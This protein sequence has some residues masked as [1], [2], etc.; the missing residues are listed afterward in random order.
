MPDPGCARHDG[1]VH[2]REGERS[3]RLRQGPFQVAHRAA[4]FHDLEPVAVPE[5]E[6]ELRPGPNP[7]PAP[8]LGGNRHLALRR[9]RGCHPSP[10]VALLLFLTSYATS[11]RVH[12][13]LEPENV[14]LTK[15]GH[16]K[17][18][19][20]G[21]ARQRPP[22]PSPEDDSSP[23][24]SVL[25]DAGTVLGTF[26]CISPEKASGK[27]VD[28]R[29]DQLSLGV[30]LQEMLTGKRPFAGATAAETLA[31]VIREEPEPL[32][33]G[34][35]EVP[36][37]VRWLVERLLSK[38]P[39][40]RYDATADLARDLRTWSLHLSEAGT[41][42]GTVS[43]AAPGRAG[44]RSWRTLP[45]SV[46]AAL[47]AVA[48]LAGALVTGPFLKGR[49][50]TSA[51]VT[52]LEIRLP[53]G[54]YLSRW[55]HSFALSPDGRL[56][57][58]SA[59]TW[60]KPFDEENA[61]RLF[62]R[63]LDSFEAR[64]IPGTVGG[65]QPVFSPDGQQVAFTATSDGRPFPKRIPV[66]GGEATTICQSDAPFV[67]AWS[68]DGSILFASMTGSLQRVSE[69]G[70]TPEAATTLD[71]SEGEVSHRLPHLLP[72][73]RT[74]VYTALRWE[75]EWLS[76]A[77]V[78]TIGQRRGENERSLLVEGGSDGRWV[79]PGN[80]LFAREGRL[81]A[82]PFD[83][84]AL[85]L[86]G[87]AAPVLEGVS[88]S[89]WTGDKY[90]ETASAMLDVSTNAFAWVPGSVTPEFQ[91]SLVWIGESGKE[92]PV[93]LPKGAVLS[94][95]I[96]PDSDQALVSY[97]YPGRQVELIDLARGARRN[98]T[99]EMNP[100]W[101]IWGPGPARIT[102][103]SDHEG[104]PRIY[105]RRIDAGPEEV[106]TPWNGT[107]HELGLGSWS[108]DGSSIYYLR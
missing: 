25:T 24:F 26:A 60:K 81:F 1:V 43:D 6:L 64:S 44:K 94:G 84:R 100:I 42:R 88:Q 74:A 15:D 30:V 39:H 2:L 92:T 56:F 61:P 73:G 63:P 23:T 108:R 11:R 65:F 106:E 55:R 89:T 78:R 46:A 36:A 47:V 77:K 93:A 95:R 16:A 103:A 80:L 31:A 5:D 53:D 86:G 19:D 50:R 58:F 72:D 28:H 33:V 91:S 4:H 57:V 17:V 10:P 85:R 102:F 7:E 67:G 66:A 32:E 41:S 14:F 29:S 45:A 59:F 82:A 90:L 12:R 87:K 20:F 71:A 34:A 51:P 22:L 70:G 97:F 40:G 96:S 27:L 9:H 3:P 79:P 38:D 68:A 98:V 35:P 62:Y 101:A 104:P 18:L 69:T 75:T 49:V 76:W 99:F 8:R 83:A 107:G 13:D 21:L 54:H 52:R 37:P 105:S 48:I